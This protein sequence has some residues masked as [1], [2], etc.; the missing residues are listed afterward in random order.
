MHDPWRGQWIGYEERELHSIR[1]SGAAWISNRGQDD[2]HH[3]GDTHH[4]FRLNFGVDHPVQL[5]HL[6][7]TGEDTAAAWVNGRHV[8][9]AEPLPPYKQT[10]WKRYVERD[11]T[12]AMKQGS[13]LLAVD[14][15]LFD[16]G[17]SAPGGSASRTPM[18]ACLYIRYQDGSDQVVVS[19][20]NWKAE[21]NASGAWYDPGFDDGTWP[22]AIRGTSQGQF[23]GP[24]D[25]RPQARVRDPFAP[26][27]PHQPLGFENPQYVALS[28]HRL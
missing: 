7:V 8:L 12:S 18:S 28:L 22:Q 20:T 6:Y 21:L 9:N 4:N 19:N 16:I 13:N 10:A 5:A 14:V 11:V 1:E 24:L 26:G 17:E 27:E 3:S 2:Y 23:T 15:T 25:G